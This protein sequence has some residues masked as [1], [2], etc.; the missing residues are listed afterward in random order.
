MLSTLIGNMQSIC[1]ELEE[2][3]LDAE[4]K[5]HQDFLSAHQLSYAMPLSPS[6]RIYILPTIFY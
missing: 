3:A 5:S 4:N 2:W 1:S 6:R